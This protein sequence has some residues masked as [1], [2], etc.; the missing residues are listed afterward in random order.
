[1]KLLTAD[2]SLKS[3]SSRKVSEIMK[4][5]HSQLALALLAVSRVCCVTCC[6][7]YYPVGY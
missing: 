1:M 6:V 5:E 7:M 2:L 3:T 4:G